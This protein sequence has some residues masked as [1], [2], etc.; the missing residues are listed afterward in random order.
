MQTEKMK[1]K[2]KKDKRQVKNRPEY[3]CFIGERGRK[4]RQR[5]REKEKGKRSTKFELLEREKDRSKKV[6]DWKKEKEKE[7]RTL[8]VFDWKKENEKG[9]RFTNFSLKVRGRKKI[10]KVTQ[11]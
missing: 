6:F 3:N 7:D 4:D 1:E 8:S 10:K 5:T 2:E 9:D 11:Y